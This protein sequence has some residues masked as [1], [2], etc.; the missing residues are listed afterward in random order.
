MSHTPTP[1]SREE[2]SKRA[3]SEGDRQN[4]VL[5]FPFDKTSAA[6]SIQA[7]LAR[8]ASAPA[9]PATEPRPDVGAIKTRYL[10]DVVKDNRSRLYDGL[11]VIASITGVTT[12]QAADAIRQV[13]YG[14]RWLDLPYT[15]PVK[16]VSG[17]E[18]EQ[19]LRLLGYVGQWRYVPYRRTLAAYL[20]ARTGIERDH[21]C[22]VSLSTHFVAVSGGVFCDVCSGGTVVDI[23][24]ADGRRKRVGGVLVLTER[25]APSAIATRAPAAKKPGEN[26]KAIRLL[27]EAIKAETG[28]I[29][30]R[31]TPHEVFVTRPAQAGWHWLG[32]RD[33]IEDQIL[34]PRPDNRLSGNT[35]AAA[36][37]RAV[38]G[39]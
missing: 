13:R 22:V 6:R 34:M 17:H 29:R 21:P 14:A 25:I 15:P 18:I 10:H 31:L 1:P 32:N 3:R 28:A 38:M 5:A 11:C 35:G 23:D 8:R 39:Y 19:A 24:N 30:I 9:K 2:T 26:G 4:N 7:E 16:W 33:S 12:S 37:Y 20:N 36:A 27:R